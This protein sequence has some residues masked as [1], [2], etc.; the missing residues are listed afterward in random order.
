M[1][2]KNPVLTVLIIAVLL[3]LNLG[4]SSASASPTVAQA[5]ST[6]LYVKPGETGDCS[7]WETACELQ[8]ALALAEAGD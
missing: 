6:I 7:S 8:T 3:F 4:L 2:T 5:Q 1:N